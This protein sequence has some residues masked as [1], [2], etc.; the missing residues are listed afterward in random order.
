MMDLHA[1]LLGAV[2][3]LSVVAVVFFLRYWRLSGDR[4]FLIFAVA[5][6]LMAVNWAAVAVTAPASES[7]HWVYAIRLLAFLVIL[8]AIVDKNRDRHP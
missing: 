5:F 7:R 8:A 4:F 1:Y 3:A 6:S 2:S